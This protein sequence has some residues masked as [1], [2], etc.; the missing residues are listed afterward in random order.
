MTTTRLVL[1]TTMAGSRSGNTSINSSRSRR[2]SNLASGR[3]KYKRSTAAEATCCTLQLTLYSLFA[4]FFDLLQAAKDS[5]HAGGGG[6]GDS[7]GD[8]G[9]T[10][11]SSN[12]SLNGGDVDSNSD[13]LASDSPSTRLGQIYLIHVGIVFVTWVVYMVCT[14]CAHRI[15]K[16]AFQEKV[17]LMEQDVVLDCENS[18]NNKSTMMLL[19]R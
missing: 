15:Q 13:E 16:A 5:H 4:M 9:N 1:N 14:C 12:P 11:H 17:E 6:N 7:H 19:S 3:F 18:Q 8:G 2:S 10:E